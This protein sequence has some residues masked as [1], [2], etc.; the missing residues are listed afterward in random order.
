MNFGFIAGFSGFRNPAH[1]VKTVHDFNVF[2][3]V[4]QGI[5]V[6][7]PVIPA[8]HGIIFNTIPGGNA[9]LHAIIRYKQMIPTS[10]DFMGGVVK[11]IVQVKF[12]NHVH[13]EIIFKIPASDIDRIGNIDSIVPEVHQTYPLSKRKQHILPVSLKQDRSV[14]DDLQGFSV[15]LMGGLP[16]C[17][18]AQADMFVLIC[19]GSAEI[20]ASVFFSCCKNSG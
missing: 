18:A 5:P 6:D 8:F 17:E 11:Q 7:K 10:H 13:C 15:C 9:H 20:D 1:A 19:D 3:A 12:Q 16:G 14:I 4:I 2:I